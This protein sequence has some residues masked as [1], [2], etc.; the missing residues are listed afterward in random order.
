[1]CDNYFFLKTSRVDNQNVCSCLYV[2]FPAEIILLSVEGK[3][4]VPLRD[5]GH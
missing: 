5:M 3:Y 1:M 4:K 2:I